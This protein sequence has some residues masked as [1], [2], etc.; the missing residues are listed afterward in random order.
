[1]REGLHPINPRLAASKSFN[2]VKTPVAH[3]APGVDTHALL[4]GAGRFVVPEIVQ[5]AQTLVEP[6]LRLGACRDLDVAVANAGH[7]DGWR[8]LAGARNGLSVGHV[9]ARHWLLGREAGR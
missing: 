7:V 8:K 6:G 4:E 2:L 5:Q 9:H 3:G 1:M